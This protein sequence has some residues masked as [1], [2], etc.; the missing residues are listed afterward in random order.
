MCEVLTNACEKLKTSGLKLASI[1]I[2]HRSPRAH[3]EAWKAGTAGYDKDFLS[4]H[5]VV[6]QAAFDNGI[7]EGY[8]A[9][10]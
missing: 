4:R 7:K 6:L 3:D 10:C 8:S 2:G 5:H 1:P 9:R